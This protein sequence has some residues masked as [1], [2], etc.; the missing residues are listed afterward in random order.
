MATDTIKPRSQQKGRQ[1]VALKPGFHLMDWMRL[2]QTRDVSGL[3][4]KPLR[5][6]SRREL[7]EHKS[8]YDCWTSYNSK[9]Y[10]MTPY[11]AYHPGGED[12]LM[13]GAGKDCTPM[14]NKFHKWV[15]MDNIMGKCHIGYLMEEHTS[16]DEDEED[17]ENENEN[18]T[19]SDSKEIETES[20]SEV[21]TEIELAIETE[22]KSEGNTRQS[23]EIV[24]MGCKDD[25]I[26][27]SFGNEKS[28][29]KSVDLV[30]KKEK[31]DEK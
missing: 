8:K 27:E 31:T 13:Q 16:F 26:E 29:E 2:T 28:D 1:K 10:N 18:E 19:K 20:K 9:V 4:G 7:A 17:S 6:I 30:K 3:N 22:K 11:V 5:R 12:F 23:D 15:N 14:F 24:D 25:C 21:A